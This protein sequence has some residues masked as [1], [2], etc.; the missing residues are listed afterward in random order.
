M[1]RTVALLCLL[2]LVAGGFSFAEDK[3]ADPKHELKQ[4]FARGKELFAD[5]SLGTNG[6]SCN[7]CHAEGGTKAGKMGDMEIPPFAH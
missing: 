4:A 3:E 5:E 6:M 7:S 1:K 2:V